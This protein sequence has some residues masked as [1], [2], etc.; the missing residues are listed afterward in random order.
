METNKIDINS[1]VLD[2]IVH[3]SNKI[4]LLE[5]ELNAHKESISR[6]LIEHKI[7]VK[8]VVKILVRE[9]MRLFNELYKTSIELMK[10]EKELE[11]KEDKPTPLKIRTYNKTE[12][13]RKSYEERSKSTFIGQLEQAKKSEKSRKKFTSILLKKGGLSEDEI[14]FR[15]KERQKE[16]QKRYRE[17]LKN[18][19]K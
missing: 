8:D 10:I 6:I 9:K 17:K 1:D 2:Y 15:N 3:T 4:F 14:K 18:S 12:V 13:W 5:N 16:Y 11:N 7:N 19:Q